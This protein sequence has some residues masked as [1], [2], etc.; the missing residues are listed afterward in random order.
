[1]NSVKQPYDTSWTG[2]KDPNLRDY[3]NIFVDRNI[4]DPIGDSIKLGYKSKFDDI[5]FVK[6]M[7]TYFHFPLKEPKATDKD[8]KYCDIEET[9]LINDGAT[10]G[11]SPYKSDRIYKMQY[12]YPNTSPYG[13]STPK[14]FNNGKWLCAWLSGDV[15]DPT[16]KPVWIDRWFDPRKIEQSDAETAEGDVHEG[17]AV[18]DVPSQMTFDYGCYYRYFRVGEST[19]RDIDK[20]I[21]LGRSMV[22]RL[23]DWDVESKKTTGGITY[24][25]P[26]E[27]SFNRYYVSDDFDDSDYA[28][29]FNGKNQLALIPFDDDIGQRTTDEYSVVF[30]AK[31]DD[32]KNCTSYAIV[33]N[34]YIGGWKFGITNRA[35]NSFIFFYGNDDNNYQQDGTMCVM[36]PNG[37][38][39]NTKNLYKSGKI[40]I[41]DMLGDI[42]LYT[43]VLSYDDGFSTISKIDFNGNMI[44]KCVI[45][46]ELKYMDLSNE[47]NGYVIFA[48]KPNVENERFVCY[49]INR[50]TM[51]ATPVVNTNTNVQA[52]IVPF[53]KSKIV[54]IKGEFFTTEKVGIW[55]AD[56]GDETNDGYIISDKSSIGGPI[57]KV[58]SIEEDLGGIRGSTVDYDNNFWVVRDDVLEKYSVVYHRY[59]K[60]MV[61]KLKKGIKPSAVDVISKYMNGELVDI[62]LVLSKEKQ[63]V[64]LYSTDGELL[65]SYGISTFFVRPCNTRRMSTYD[66]Y[67]RNRDMTK[68]VYFD[69]CDFSSRMHNRIIK[70]MEYVSDKEWHQ[71]SVVVKRKH[72]ELSL[73]E[74][75]YDVTFYF[76]CKEVETIE[77]SGEVISNKKSDEKGRSTQYAYDNPIVLGGRCGKIFSLMEEAGF[78]NTSFK[79]CIDDF[80]IYNRAITREDLYYIY[81]TKFKCDDLIWHFPTDQRNFVENIERFYKFKMPGSK[82]AHYELH[83]NGYKRS[84]GTIDESVKKVLED[85]IRRALKR[86]APAY[87]TMTKIIWD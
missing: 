6:D 71:F 15:L 32:W 43:Y 25:N 84:D 58:Y 69:I 39:L 42:D 49:E 75:K 18:Y 70:P 62:I 52:R 2:K 82:S 8:N 83:I 64:Y 65:G 40:T 47:K 27:D 81:M 13:S 28:V 87:S 86:L 76:D 60:Q 22:L 54:E 45:D 7:Y 21:S 16:S 26:T 23:E 50:Y 68:C 53:T 59:Q 61:V 33:D 29:H 56:N 55:I 78:A 36:N 11:S 73:F 80:R 79:G 48:Y 4:E 24:L 77:I 67:L 3:T 19:I 38:L 1:M 31:C 66:W 51:E 74:G 5:V 9:T 46:A 63:T 57:I 35:D 85:M 37:D 44:S 41:V 14:D 72:N 12:D 10:Y 30:W 20:T 17:G 34:M